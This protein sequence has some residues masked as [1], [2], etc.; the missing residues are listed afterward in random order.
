MADSKLKRVRADGFFV[1][2][3]S[4]ITAGL[5]SGYKPGAYLSEILSSEIGESDGHKTRVPVM[6]LVD[7][8]Y[9][10]VFSFSSIT[11]RQ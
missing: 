7:W 11:A 6:C 3:S 10:A 5:L 4:V 9:I 1:P 2:L 8:G